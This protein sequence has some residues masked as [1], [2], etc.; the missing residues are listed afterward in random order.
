MESVG[1]PWVS[2]VLGVPWGE[3]GKEDGLSRLQCKES[4]VIP[5]PQL[6]ARTLLLTRKCQVPIGS[7]GRRGGAD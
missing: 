6:I 4:P 5:H 2:K 1:A 7:S 3:K